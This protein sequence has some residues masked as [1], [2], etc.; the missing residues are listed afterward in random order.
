MQVSDQAGGKS[1]VWDG[2]ERNGAK[3]MDLDTK[4]LVARCKQKRL[5]SWKG[6]IAMSHSWYDENVDRLVG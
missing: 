2:M 5:D 1:I 3:L 4:P 6:V